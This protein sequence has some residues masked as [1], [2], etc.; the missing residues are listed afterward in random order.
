MAL[1][2]IKGGREGIFENLA[3]EK[4]LVI[5][6]WP[7][8]GDLSKI[9]SKEE[10]Y[11]IIKQAYPDDSPIKLSVHMG[12]LWSFSKRIKEGDLV[13]MPSKKKPIIYIGKITGPYEYKEDI[14]PDARHVRSVNWLKEIP[15]KDLAQD[16]L[17]SFGS[18][19]T[20]CQITR[21]NAEERIKAI[22]EK[23]GPPP[24]PV[25]GEEPQGITDIEEY[26][27]D[28][29]R[30]YIS[31]NFKGHDLARLV[32]AVLEAQGYKIYVSPPGPDGG[33]DIICGRG[34]LGFDGPKLVVQVK[35]SDSPVDIKPI[36]EFHGVMSHYKADH[37][38]FVSWGGYKSSVEKE[39]A[40]RYFE[41]RLWDSDDLIKAI[42]DNYERL[43][44]EIQ[45]ELPLKRIW[46][47][48]KKEE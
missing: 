47:L 48:V 45:A 42:L 17:F 41:I 43:S 44:D 21:N 16:L 26:S 11:E 30:N 34:A 14:H 29:I 6:G 4:N 7:K 31:Q 15:R 27:F 39:E 5:I 13:V 20:V 38:L 8:I 1:W 3:I 10:L 36:R 19:L 40:Q 25:G 23:K 9:N 35:S 22:I 46:T 12:Q 24:E 32:S 28:L 18:M 2:L 37:G 33:V